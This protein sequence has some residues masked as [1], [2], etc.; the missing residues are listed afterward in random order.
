MYLLSFANTVAI[1]T[2]MCISS[3][4]WSEGW[5][6]LRHQITRQCTLPGRLV[7]GVFLG[8]EKKSA[9]LTLNPG[10]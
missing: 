9:F 2:E 3:A 7:I 1:T 5:P 6:K 10:I 4:L 8:M